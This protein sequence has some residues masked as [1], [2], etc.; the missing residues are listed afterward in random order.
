[1]KDGSVKTLLLCTILVTT[2][3]P[4]IASFY[5]LDDALERSLNLGFNA[6]IEQALAIAAQNLKALKT[7]DAANEARYREEFERISTLAHVY[8]EPEILKRAMRDSLRVYFG[9]GLAGAVLMAVLVA[10]LL[11]RRINHF[12]RLAF[13]ELMHQRDRVRYLE[14]MSS[15]QELARILAHE[16]KNP[17][18]PIEVMVTA[19]SRAH[20]EKS[21]EQF[22]AQLAA[23]Q[24]MIQEE[25][26]HLET[27]VSRFSDFA[28]LP[29]ARLVTANPVD[30]VRGHLPAVA[31]TFEN[32][33]VRLHAVDCPEDL[34][35]RL[36][37][38]LLRQVLMNIV[39]NGVEANPGRR[40]G[41]DILIRC[42]SEAIHVAIANDGVPVPAEIAVHMFDPYIS[43]KAGKDN[44]GLGLAI[45]KK[46]VIEHG[47]EI[48]YV[49]ED[50]RPCF[51]LTVARVK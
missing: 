28:R 26:S 33:D 42:D 5:F 4:L 30:V 2:G 1:M 15:W 50:G 25:I 35:A 49:E 23:T 17:L 8:A 34:R 3:V 14:Q 18:T 6:R 32:A 38:S 7:L 19:L 20:A 21:C 13:D 46:I 43:G 44:V 9:V 31:A 51:T 45:V 41:F 39:A 12:Y 47:G 48:A 36:D 24:T 37:S 10:F 27:T 22:R 16:I 11:G 40:V 29:P